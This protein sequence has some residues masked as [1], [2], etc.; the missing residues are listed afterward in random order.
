VVNRFQQERWEAVRKLGPPLETKQRKKIVEQVKSELREPRCVWPKTGPWKG[1]SFEVET[2]GF[3]ILTRFYIGM[4][5]GIGYDHAILDKEKGYYWAPDT[6]FHCDQ[7]S[8]YSWLG[9]SWQT[10][11]LDLR[12]GEV[13]RVGGEL[14]RLSRHLLDGVAPLLDDSYLHR[15]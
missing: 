9:I 1:A 2:G 3:R 12:V 6:T 11:W 4:R 13:E 10:M 7:L 5:T 14:V 15:S 8:I